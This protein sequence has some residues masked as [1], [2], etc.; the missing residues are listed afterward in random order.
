[1]A[2]FAFYAASACL[3]VLLAVMGYPFYT[4][5]FWAVMALAVVM[6][7]AHAETTR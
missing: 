4:W 3:G 1:M 2:R 5:Q 7:V 6:F